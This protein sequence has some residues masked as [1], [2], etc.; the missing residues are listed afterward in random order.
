MEIRTTSSRTV[1]ENRW[2]AVREHAILRSNGRQGIYGVVHKP[3]FAL[4]IPVDGDDLVMVEQFR[5][6]VADRLLEFPQGSWQERPDAD[7]EELARGE[8]EEEAG[9]RASSVRFLGR[10]YGAPGTM[11]QGFNVF[12][13]TDLAPGERKLDPEEEGMTVHRIR[14]EEFEPM[15]AR[16]EI[17]DGPTLAAW[18]LWRA[19]AGLE[20][21]P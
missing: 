6:P 20:I 18:S 1:Y 2:M 7:P 3:D 10:L 17:V 16:G 19:S 5:Y 15:T 8:L 13:A 21:T 11:A 12:L 14:R 9:V 4:V